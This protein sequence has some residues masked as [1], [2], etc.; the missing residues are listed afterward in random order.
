MQPSLT[1][2]FEEKIAANIT[3]SCFFTPRH[4]A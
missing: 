3:S 4:P 2:A 1:K